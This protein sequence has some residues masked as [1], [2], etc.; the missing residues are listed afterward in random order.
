MLELRLIRRI[1]LMNI[2]QTIDV[3]IEFIESFAFIGE[4]SD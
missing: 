4:S 1:K 2:S 3:Q